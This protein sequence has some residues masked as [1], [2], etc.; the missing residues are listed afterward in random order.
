M[1][2]WRSSPTHK[3]PPKF[4][5]RQTQNLP[6]SGNL[7]FPKCTVFKRCWLLPLAILVMLASPTSALHLPAEDRSRRLPG[8]KVFEARKNQEIAAVEVPRVRVWGREKNGCGR[9]DR[10]RLQSFGTSHRHFSSMSMSTRFVSVPK[11]QTFKTP[12]GGRLDKAE[13][14]ITI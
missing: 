3:D 2:S 12:A 9:R 13:R 1:D 14:E 8:L 4:R 7:Q 11:L 5:R 10:A 6:R